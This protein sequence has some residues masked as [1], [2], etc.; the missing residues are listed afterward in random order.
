MIVFKSCAIKVS[1]HPQG[2]TIS[3]GEGMSAVLV[4]YSQSSVLHNP[5]T[6]IIFGGIMILVLSLFREKV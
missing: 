4:A 2:I 1:K 3:Y 5:Y 6:C